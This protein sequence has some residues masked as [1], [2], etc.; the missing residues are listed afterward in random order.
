MSTPVLYDNPGPRTRRRVLL[1]SIVAGA[2]LL[3][4]LGLALY[5]LAGQDQLSGERWGPLVNPFDPQFAAVWSGL[6]E[7]L[8]LNITAAALA[9]V[10]SLATGTLLALTRI[11]S[12]AWYRWAVVGVIEV[13]RGLPVVIAIFLSY[14]I[15]PELGVELPRIWYLVIGLTAYNAVVIAE[16]VRAG[17]AS[18]PRGQAEAASAIG[19]TRG[20][21]L[22]LVQLPQAFRIMLPALISQLVVV[23]KDTSLGFVILFPEAISFARIAIQTLSNPLQLYFVIAILFIAINYLLSRF[24]QW[25]E[26][27]LSRAVPAAATKPAVFT[28]ESAALTGTDRSGR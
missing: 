8:L 12:A 16:I 7:A 28:D 27:R 18:L 10:L 13:L 25:V 24:A 4:V 11:T 5:R 2:V 9:M 21:S 23:F 6:L 17:V 14:R 15:L 26:R 20:Q 3:A 19:L 22:R 1:G